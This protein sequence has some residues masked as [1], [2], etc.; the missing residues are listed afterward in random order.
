M[1]LP[2]SMNFNLDTDLFHANMLI[3]VKI[4]ISPHRIFRN[5]SFHIYPKKLNLIDIEVYPRRRLN[6]MSTTAF[7]AIRLSNSKRLTIGTYF[8]WQY[9]IN[10]LCLESTHCLIKKPQTGFYGGSMTSI[11][12][13]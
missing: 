9:T 7:I 8:S 6:W 2:A 3:S 12:R 10:H 4:K 13:W 5:I 11:R 1:R